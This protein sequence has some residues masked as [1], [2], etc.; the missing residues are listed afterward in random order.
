MSFKVDFLDISFV[1]FIKKQI[2]NV[3]VFGLINEMLN[4]VLKDDMKNPVMGN[5][6]PGL[7]LPVVTFNDVAKSKKIEVYNDKIILKI[8]SRNIFLEKNKFN[9][10]Y[11]A[12]Q[13]LFE[14]LFCYIKKYEVI[15][16]GIIGKFFLTLVKE[17][18]DI[19]N[20][21][22]EKMLKKT[23]P[24]LQDIKLFFSQ[25][26][27]LETCSINDTTSFETQNLI[28]PTQELSS[29]KVKKGLLIKKDL[30]TPK[31]NTVTMTTEQFNTLIKYVKTMFCETEIL[32]YMDN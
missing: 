30:N 29:H 21:I 31:N 3:N 28:V 9:T 19:N 8:V 2:N 10:Y 14:A 18:K 12:N 24:E 20:I 7:P 25:K 1:F 32:K 4:E 27:S 6:P 15:R 16:I 5:V 26:K 23:V 17:E 11:D 22:A 13:N